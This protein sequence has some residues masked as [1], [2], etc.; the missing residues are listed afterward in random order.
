MFWHVD[1]MAPVELMRERLR[2]ILARVPLLGRPRLCGQVVTDTTPNT[3]QVPALVTAK[4]ADDIWTVRVTVREQMVRWLT[5]HHPY[6]LPRVNTADAVTAPGS[7]AV[8]GHS[9]NGE[10]P[11]RAHETP[12]TGRA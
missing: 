1:H 3:M 8:D 2:D 4:D 10:A 7:R 5:E 9:L 12:R 6:A 11:R